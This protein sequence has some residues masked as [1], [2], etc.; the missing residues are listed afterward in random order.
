ML[1]AGRSR[2]WFPMKPLD[3]SIDLILPA[4]LWPWGL[5][6]LWQKWVPGIFLGVKGGWHIMLP[7]SLPSESQLSR[8]CG[9][10]DVSQPNGPPRPVAGIALPL[11]FILVSGLQSCICWCSVCFDLETGTECESTGTHF[12]LRKES[13]G[14][15]YINFPKQW[16]LLLILIFML[17]LY[18]E[19]AF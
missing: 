5:L 18:D 1:Q 12:F 17:S 13:T 16:P 8:K 4:A 2:V 9:S 14:C 7:T 15:N 10:L 19:T 3:F 6:S 11:S